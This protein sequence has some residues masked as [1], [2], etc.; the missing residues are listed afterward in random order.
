MTKGREESIPVPTRR[1][2]SDAGRQ[3]QRGHSSAAKVLND[4]KEA[5]K[6][7]LA[8]PKNK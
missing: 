4:Q 5:I 6:E 7:G 3:L 8:K 2:L 1:E